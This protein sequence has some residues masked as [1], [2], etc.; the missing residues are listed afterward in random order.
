MKKII[1]LALVIIMLF[2]LCACGK[3]EEAPAPTDAPVADE[4]AIETVE[5]TAEP[6]PA[7]TPE[8]TPVG[9]EH[10][11]GIYSYASEDGGFSFDYDSKYAPVENFVGNVSVYAGTDT[12]IPYCIIALIADT[13]AVSYLKGMA[14]GAKI[15]LGDSLVAEAGEPES[16]DIEGRD[17]SYIYYTYNNAD[18]GGNVVCFIY[19]E[20]L[21]SG[22]VVAYSS[23]AVEG[24]TADVDSIID[25]AI[26]TFK[27]V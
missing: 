3:K 11:S 9:V 10:D 23:Y 4:P 26:K 7:P 8:P 17:I 25:L 24:E 14:E 18:M 15:E 2:A 19:A 22:E 27:M 20:N 6:T 21:E 12:G 13:D 1:S 16:A 5:P